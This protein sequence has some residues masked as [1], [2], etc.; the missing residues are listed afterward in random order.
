MSKRILV[1]DDDENVRDTISLLLRH[2]GFTVFTCSTGREIFQ[3]I[4]RTTPDLILLD[5][6]LGELDGRAI[7]KAIKNNPITSYIPVIIL[8]GVY[9]IYNIILDE[10]A[11]DVLPKPFTEDVLLARVGRQLSLASSAGNAVAS[12]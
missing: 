3:T 5:V 10:K 8:S 1:I 11:N 12:V 2:K 9:N 4:Q 7:C 6:M